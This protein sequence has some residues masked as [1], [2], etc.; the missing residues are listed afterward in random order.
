MKKKLLFIAMLAMFCINSFAQATAY[1]V[2]D[3]SVCNATAVFDLT[4]QTP[5]ALGNQSPTDYSVTYY[6]SEA[7]AQAGT[8]VITNPAAY[9]STTDSEIFIRVENI[10]TG[11][12]DIT[13]FYITW[14]V[15]FV[16]WGDVTV[17][18]SYTLPTISWPAVTFY[19]GPNA[20]G[21]IVPGGS[22]ITSTQTLYGVQTGLC[23]NEWSFDITIAG[24]LPDADFEPLTMCDQ[25]F[26]G[27]ATF[28]LEMQLGY[29]WSLYPEYQNINIELYETEADAQNQVNPIFDYVYTNT[30]PN[31]QTIYIRL[32]AQDCVSIEPLTL[33]V[34]PCITDNTI[35]GK[36]RYD[37]DD[38]G[39]T[40][41]DLVAAGITVY[42]VHDNNYYYT[43][44][45]ENGNYSFLNVPD[46]EVT[47]YP[48]PA[49]P[50]TAS[51][52]PQ[53]YAFAFP[54]NEEDIDFC[55]TEQQ[56]TVDVAVYSYP[57]TSFVPGF[58]A[59]YVIAYQNT[60][61]TTVDSGNITMS[62][63]N[64]LL[65]Y[66]G[67]SST[68]V[69]S[70]NQLTFSYTNLEPYQ[71]QYIYVYFTVST[72]AVSGN[73]VAFST[74]ITPLNDDTPGNNTFESVAYVV[75]SFDP[76]DI[77]VREGE[78]I[79][80][81][82]A[83]DYLHYTI[84]FQNM[85]DANATFVRI[86]TNL[87]ENLDLD[88]F[89]AIGGSHNYVANRAGNSLEFFFDD[90]NLPFEDADEPGSHGFVSFKIKPKATVGIGDVMTGQAG[91]YFDFNPV[92]DTN[93]A[94]TT[95]EATAGIKDLAANG[96]ALYPNPASGK[97]T[98]L[99]QNAEAG[100]VTVTDVLG[101]TMFTTSLNGAQSNLDVSALKTGVYFVSVTANG[102]QSTKKLVIK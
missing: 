80:E 34:V 1:E 65:T 28:F 59:T 38:N 51:V 19:T 43:T 21:T 42:Y 37:S 20:T 67:A 74:A 44:T 79:T 35:A 23:S 62:F 99:L 48:N 95:V 93:I 33:I 101:K 32:M 71:T 14:N 26:D 3:L 84:R 102:K 86:A 25:D 17:C 61:S 56:P 64:S 9:Y 30:T 75:S 29:M 88:T 22:V 60:G 11:D 5:I 53:N 83:D 94:T 24:S 87:N 7:N 31:Q 76:N 66:D 81:A 78:F 58:P 13:S 41:T 96:F 39:C 6:Y 12:Y 18:T 15:M 40:E 8:N 50:F 4:V 63:D 54:G 100:N 98:L 92:V 45:D 55:L 89:Q 2:P 73:T 57:V 36:I 49:Y 90:I 97:V 91:I 46:G 16:P 52:A 72:A 47:V 70:G 27:Y 69:V 85:G 77:S 68:A 82:Q 10:S